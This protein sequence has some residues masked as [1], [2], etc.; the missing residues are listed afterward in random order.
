MGGVLELRVTV[1]GTGEALESGTLF[2]YER[3][4]QGAWIAQGMRRFDGGVARREGLHPGREYCASV[5]PIAD[6]LSALVQT[7]T[8]ELG[9]HAVDAVMPRARLVEVPVPADVATGGALEVVAADPHPDEA[10]PWTAPIEGGA[11]RLHLRPGAYTARVAGADAFD[12]EV[13]SAFVAV[14]TGGR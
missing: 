7:W 10:A 13:T 6:H 5:Q 14:P 12:F 8:A 2:L 11:A 9:V 3:S 4:P 1:E